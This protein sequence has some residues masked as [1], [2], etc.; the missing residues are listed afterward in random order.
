MLN[1]SMGVSEFNSYGCTDFWDSIVFVHGL[2]GDW[3]ETWTF[4][5]E[6]HRVNWM[7]D[8]LPDDIQSHKHVRILSYGYSPYLFSGVLRTFRGNDVSPKTL[9]KKALGWVPQAIN[10]HANRLLEQLSAKRKGK[11][12]DRA[13]IWIGH[14]L[15]GLI[16]QKALVQASASLESRIEHKAIELC[17]CGVLYFGT[18]MREVRGQTWAQLLSSIVSYSMETKE[19]PGLN[20]PALES[21]ILDLEVQRYK[22]ILTNFQNYS[23]CEKTEFPVSIERPKT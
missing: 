10:I 7:T 2:M 19:D 16:V 20:L 3:R 12:R 6:G 22:S 21:D 18:P 15:G 11:D 8:L 13:I 4:S 1:L 23:F 9:D 5:S 17:T 14:S